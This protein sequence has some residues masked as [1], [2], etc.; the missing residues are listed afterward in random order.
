[1]NCDGARRLFVWC[2][3]VVV[4][5]I[6][7]QKNPIQYT[8][9]ISASKNSKKISKYS[10]RSL[11]KMVKSV[12]IHPLVLLSVVDHYNRVAKDTSRRVVGVLLGEISKGKVD[13][14]NSFAVPYESDKKDPTVWF[15]DHNYLEEMA[16]MFRKVNARELIVGFYSSSPKI[17]PSD[18]AI[19]ELFRRFCKDPVFTI[20]DVRADREDSGL[21]VKAFKMVEEIQEGTETKRVFQHIPSEIGAYEAE[22]VGVEHLLR[23]V[24][25]PTISTLAE[26]IRHQIT[27]LKG[28]RNR[29]S[30]M[31][32]YI[33]DVANGKRKVNNQIIY[34]IQTIVNKLPNLNLSKLVQS[35]M[36]KTND[37]YLVLY[38]ASI[39][40]SITALHDLVNNKLK[41]RDM[42][43][44]AQKKEEDEKK[45]KQKEEE[46]KKKK[47]DDKKEQVETTSG[48]AEESKKKN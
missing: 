30:E 42:K 15:V 20:I 4:V 18:L 19:A 11:K 16:A 10:N 45:K 41:F 1:M 34:N 37:I 33:D 7:H 38:V 43:T 17:E 25:D 29:L 35:F 24:N 3:V 2:V 9:S 5:V 27:A 21:P 26:R 47:A 46:A 32:R 13:V 28:L 8:L 40:R 36:V 39:I 44:A 22:E 12:V 31:S 14:T 23:D 6:Y 48:K